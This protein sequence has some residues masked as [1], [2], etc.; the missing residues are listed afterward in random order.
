MRN[1]ARKVL[2][3]AGIGIAIPALA[4]A[5]LWLVGTGGRT[6]QANP[7]LTLGIDANPATTPDSN[8]DGFY[9]EPLNWSLLEACRQVA[10]G[11]DF[12]VDVFVAEVTDLTAFDIW[13]KYDPAKLSVTGFDAKGTV[14]SPKFLTA[15]P[16]SAVYAFGAEYP[17]PPQPHRYEVLAVDT[18]SPALNA[19][20]SGSGVLVRFSLHAKAQGI[21]PLSVNTKVDTDGDTKI[22]NGT[23]LQDAYSKR[24][25]DTNGD[26]FFDGRMRDGAIGINTALPDS[27]ND[28]IPDACDNCPSD[29]NPNQEDADLDGAGDACDN[30]LNNSNPMQEDADSDDV[31]DL[32]DNCPNASN[33][34]QEDADED[35]TGNACD[36]DDDGDGFSD[37][38]ETRA[39]SDGLNVA[40]NNASN[41][42]PAD[43]SKT[44]DGCVRVHTAESQCDGAADDDADGYVNDG[45]PVVGTKPEGSTPEVCDNA[46]VDE[47]RDGSIN[48]GYDYNPANGVPDC[49]DPAANTDGDGMFN[50]ADSDDDN[51]GIPDAAENYIGT[52]SLDKCPDNSNDDA[53]PPD[54][55]NDRSCNVFDLMEYIAG[56]RLVSQYG[57]P[58]YDRRF[59]LTA[60]GTINIFDLMTFVALNAL[61]S[62][63]TN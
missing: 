1:M 53:W 17:P 28:G 45:C 5:S 44:N 59:D 31:G 16:D 27:D 52:D 12:T 48:E 62:S 60:D 3:G 8:G 41:D 18:Y 35:G 7:G 50:P 4:V 51:D 43:D 46:L 21:S 15:D 40:C 20:E 25:G 29:Q 13:L 11:Q 42:D 37:G 58:T 10:T 61:G 33:P 19:A 26:G 55:N 38:K 2:F 54:I 22:D 49:T 36:W 63:C 39:G 34:N 57:G 6:A 56:G 24:L 14:G 47:D 23:Y 30:C 32:C 9:E